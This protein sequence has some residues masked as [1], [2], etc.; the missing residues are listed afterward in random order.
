MLE[1]NKFNDKLSATKYKMLN[2][3]RQKDF[4][5]I[6]FPQKFFPSFSVAYSLGNCGTR[7]RKNKNI[8]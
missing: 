3:A 2:D 6:Y 4:H 5:A 1:T 7:E 8:I